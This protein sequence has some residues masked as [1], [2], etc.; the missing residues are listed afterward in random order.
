MHPGQ[1]WDL[2]QR[3]SRAVHDFV[4]D[5]GLYAHSQRAAD[6]LPKGLPWPRAGTGARALMDRCGLSTHVE[7]DFDQPLHRMALLP[8]HALAMVAHRAGWTFHVEDLQRVVL[9]TEIDVLSSQLQLSPKDWE[10]L[11]ELAPAT[12]S[13][14]QSPP[15]AP[16]LSLEALIRRIPSVGWQLI[17]AACQTL[18][19]S[20]ARRVR[21]KLPLWD[22]Q[23]LLVPGP[24]DL[25]MM[26][27]KSYVWAATQWDPQWEGLWTEALAVP[28]M[29]RA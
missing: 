25:S 13:D 11:D 19:D 8:A 23:E 22:R 27:S 21:L 5:P 4:F 20:V 26:V 12:I 24:R 29:R 16:R 14:N 10:A 15:R 28:S 9:K 2:P 17:D 18:P 3:L 7:L 1:L 6:L